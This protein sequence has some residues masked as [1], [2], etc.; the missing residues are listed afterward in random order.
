MDFTIQQAPIATINFS[1]VKNEEMRAKFLK[2]KENIPVFGGNILREAEFDDGYFL[3]VRFANE[4]M[5]N[6]WLSNVESIK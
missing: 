6:V 2:V 4:T 1:G 3:E 5:K